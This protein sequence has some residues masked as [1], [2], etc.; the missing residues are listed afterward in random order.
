MSILETIVAHKKKEVE[1]CKKLIGLNDL[2]KQEY[3]SRQTYSFT[4]SLCASDKTGIVAEFKRKS[5]SKGIINNRVQVEEITA[6]YARAGASALS[7]LT[8]FNFFGGSADDLLKARKVNT[9]PILRK[10]FIIDIYQVMESKAMGADAILL[11]AAIINKKQAREL[12]KA[13]HEMGLQV[14][15]EFHDEKELDIINEYVDV[16]GINNRNLN[17]FVVSLQVSVDM[18]PKLPQGMMKISE[19]GIAAPDDIVFLS[20]HGYNGFLIGENFMKTSDPAM[21]FTSFA[22]ALKVRNARK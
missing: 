11:I 4:E 5:P 13:A 10:E 9:I 15:M 3:F 19:S 16:A 17:T 21:A 1:S 22:E 2:K 12:G 14:L 18:A 20:K 7:V 8:D 6:G